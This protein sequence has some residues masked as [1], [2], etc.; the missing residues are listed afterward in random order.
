MFI[1]RLFWI[2]VFLAASS[3]LPGFPM[4]E[5]VP[6]PSASA[7]SAV[8]AAAEPVLP[9]DNRLNKPATAAATPPLLPAA[10][11]ATSRST[12]PSSAQAAL[13]NGSASQLW[14][15]HHEE[16]Q[17]DDQEETNFA[18]EDDDLKATII[19]KYALHSVCS[20]QNIRLFG[21]RFNQ[22][23][24]D[25]SSNDLYAQLTVRSVRLGEV[26]ISNDA[27][28]RFLCFNRHGKLIMRLEFRDKACVFHERVHH[29]KIVLQSS[30]NK[31]WF[32]GFGRD[33]RSLQG[34]EWRKKQPK[35]RGCY[36]FHRVGQR[37]YASLNDVSHDGESPAHHRRTHHLAGKHFPAAP[38]TAR[39]MRTSSSDTAEVPL[40]TLLYQPNRRP[41][42]LVS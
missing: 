7:S 32:V 31:T 15:R 6:V 33:G 25:A 38:V 34:A 17:E 9:L 23:R 5:C 16:D 1:L 18:G 10:G 42:R 41:S 28:G 14:R 24:A 26:S 40:K 19:K 37:V 22:V 29:E 3:L 39:T 2:I 27:S 20:R 4:V 13:I 35:S 12:F 21:K 36:N 30:L 11:G 8:V